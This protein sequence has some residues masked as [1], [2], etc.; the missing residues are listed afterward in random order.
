MVENIIYAEH[1]FSF[2]GEN[3][4]KLIPLIASVYSFKL[5]VL[6]KIADNTTTGVDARRDSPFF[7]FESATTLPL[8]NLVAVAKTV[9][10]FSAFY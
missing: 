9:S 7:L 6:P 8:N 10:P 5:G 3:L 1:S 4:V 2:G